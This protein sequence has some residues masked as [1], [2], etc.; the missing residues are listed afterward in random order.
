MLLQPLVDEKVSSTKWPFPVEDF[1]VKK[2]ENCRVGKEEVE[3]RTKVPK[4]TASDGA[5]FRMWRQRLG[6]C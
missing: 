5:E 1:K 2:K 4:A 3:V 6:G